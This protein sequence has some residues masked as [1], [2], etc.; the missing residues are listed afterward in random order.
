MQDNKQKKTLYFGVYGE[1]TITKWL[2]KEYKDKN[3]KEPC[4]RSEQKAYDKE[5]SEY[6]AQKLT[7]G[8]GGALTTFFAKDLQEAKTTA[9][10]MGLKSFSKISTT[11][12][13]KGKD[14]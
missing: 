6:I 3:S 8:A 1:E 10:K 9:N 14:F 11:V 5:E 7:N 12:Y 13:E 2:K 4:S